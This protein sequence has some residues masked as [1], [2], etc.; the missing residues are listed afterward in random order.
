[1]YEDN[2]EYAA[3]RL[4]GTIVMLKGEP[5][6]VKEVLD[7][8]DL[9]Y[10]PLAAPDT[11]YLT[12]LSEL[13]VVGQNQLGYVNYGGSAYY[14]MRKPIRGDWRQGLRMAN[15]AFAGEEGFGRLPFRELR[16]TILGQYPSFEE[17]IDLVKDEH[18]ERCAFSRG[19]A[20]NRSGS[21]LYKQRIVGSYDKIVT[22]M[23]HYKYLTEYLEEVLETGY[24]KN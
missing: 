10:S 12:A 1:V 7:N 11:D 3:G 22:L 15:L 9:I 8:G 2:I 4:D 13:D 14:L 21:L 5:I 24:A 16:Q 20:V 6:Y 19:F 18:W 23:E 17:A